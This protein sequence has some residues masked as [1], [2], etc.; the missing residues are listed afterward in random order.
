M[1]NQIEKAFQDNG[2]L[3]KLNEPYDANDG[4]CHALDS[5]TSY[6]YPEITEGV[7]LEMRNDFCQKIEWRERLINI[8]KPVINNL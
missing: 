8:L 2:V 5:M 6:R 7:L 3:Y 1:I 4:L